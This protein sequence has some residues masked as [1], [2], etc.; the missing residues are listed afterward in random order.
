VSTSFAAIQYIRE[1]FE[2]ASVTP[3]MKCPSTRQ[4]MVS[5]A[6]TPREVTKIEDK[7]I[8]LLGTG[9]IGRA[10]CRN[11]VDYLDTRNITLIN[12]TGEK[13]IAIAS[14]LGLKHA[15]IE[16]LDN[17]LRSADI[18]LIS[19]NAAQ[20]VVFKEH[21]EGAGDKLVIDLSVPCNV[22]A[23]AQVLHSVTFVDVD[24]LSRIKDETLQKRVAEVPKAVS[25]IA[26]HMAEFEQ[27][28]NMRNHVPV[29][30]A[31]KNKLKT[32]YIDPV[33]LGG[34]DELCPTYIGGQDEKIQK[35]INTLATKIRRDNTPGCNYIQAINEFIA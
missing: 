33:L 4:M 25:I 1:Y 30:K 3:E 29:L 16:D 13:A 10:T 32:I 8:V 28:Y 12:R 14:E 19:T 35:V 17:E 24:M 22:D 31:V 2:G 9:K 20:P 15:P 34:N 11:L 7:K 21:L 5:P 18:I 6:A 26:E 27:W 23:A